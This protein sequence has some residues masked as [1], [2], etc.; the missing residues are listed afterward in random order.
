MSI[1][2]HL[3]N[4]T[5]AVALYYDGETTPHISAHGQDE[6]AQAIVALAIANDIPV[7][8]NAELVRWLGQLDVGEEI[9]EQLYRIVAEILAFVYRLEDRLPGQP[10]K[11][12]K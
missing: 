4:T 6:L 7:Y 11:H 8:E 5:E 9:P 3:L 12:G 2:E 10:R 1:P